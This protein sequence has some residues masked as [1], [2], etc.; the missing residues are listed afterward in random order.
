MVRKKGKRKK[1]IITIVKKRENQGDLHVEIFLTEELSQEIDYLRREHLLQ[2]KLL[3]LV[4]SPLLAKQEATGGTKTI[5]SQ[6]PPPS[7]REISKEHTAAI[8]IL[9]TTLNRQPMA[10]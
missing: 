6:H 8:P 5:A 3:T 9:L 2:K 1:H 10:P 4:I 7:K